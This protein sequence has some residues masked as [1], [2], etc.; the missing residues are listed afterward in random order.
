MEQLTL[1]QTSSPLCVIGPTP[2]P[3]RTATPEP[4][5]LAQDDWDKTT[6]IVYVTLAQMVCGVAK[7]LTKLGGKTVT[8]LVTPDE[9]ESR[10]FKLVSLVTGT[11]P[12]WLR[13]CM[14][15]SRTAAASQRVCLD[16]ITLS[17]TPLTSLD[18]S[19]SPPRRAG[20]KNSLKGV[21]YFLG[22]ALLDCDAEWGYEIT[23]GVLIGLILMAYPW[24]IL[25]LDKVYA[26]QPPS[27]PSL[28]HR[29]RRIHHATKSPTTVCP[30]TQH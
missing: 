18:L 2:T 25:S 16:V 21:G 13:V 4:P 27:P 10:L 11:H 20:W 3:T 9:Q 5:P 29:R 22:A 30:S 8:K 23:L 7:D 19:H 6:A 15:E 26:P 24:T 28:L 12:P 1:T 14:R 17:P